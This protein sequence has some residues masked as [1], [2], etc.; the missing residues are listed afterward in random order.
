MQQCQRLADRHTS[1]PIGLEL[2]AE[3]VHDLGRQF[4]QRHRA[5]AREDV[6]VPQH[7]VELQRRARQVGSRVQTPPL[8]A[9][10]AERLL[11][12]V[13]LR[14]L[15]GALATPQLAVEGLRVAFAA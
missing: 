2:D 12:R 11:A 14:Q 8:L 10:L 4:A 1:H 7:R 6:R 5:Q 3:A 9:E 13:E 15:A